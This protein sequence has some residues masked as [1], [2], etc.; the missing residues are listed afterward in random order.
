MRKCVESMY[1]NN[2]NKGGGIRVGTIIPIAAAFMA[3]VMG[4]GFSTGNEVLQCFGSYGIPGGFLVILTA[5]IITGYFASASYRHGMTTNW[6]FKNDHD[7]YEYIAQNK[8]L[9]YVFDIFIVICIGS[10]LIS[11]FSGVGTTLN[12]YFGI[13]KMAGALVLGALSC[14]VVISGIKWVHR[15]L[16][17]IGIILI[18]LVYFI[19]I[20]AMATKGFDFSSHLGNLKSYIADGS[21]YQAGMLG[22][23]HWLLSGINYAGV[24][25]ATGLPFYLK[26]G[27]DFKTKKEANVGGWLASAFVYFGV[28]CVMA[29]IFLNLDEI[30]ANTSAVPTLAAI[31]NMAPGLSWIFVTV[32]VLAI[33]STITGYLSVMQNRFTKEK[34]PAAYAV[35]IGFAAVG[36]FLGSVLPFSAIVN[37]IY[38]YTGI[39][40]VILVVLLI[41]RDIRGMGKPP[42]DA[43]VEE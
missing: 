18:V 2:F 33:F 36:I 8:I 7:A 39:F 35:V 32:L 40:G 30:V 42:A 25:L 22:K 27:N 26:Q 24:V 34:T 4:S 11:M 1:N 43:K 37:F 28:F 12:V 20:Y 31:M 15:V 16:G 29:A 38:N 5:F 41:I 10:F 13:P 21:I 17:Y 3:Y 19:G 23:N 9:A 6:E 14:I